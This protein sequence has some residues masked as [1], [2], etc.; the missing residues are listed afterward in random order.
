M[1]L[2]DLKAAVAAA[3]VALG[4][5]GLVVLSFGNVSG[6]D[7]AAGVLVIKPSGVPYDGLTA[8]DMVV[9]RLEDGS[10]V[11]GDLR[12]S[13]DTPTHRLLYRELPGIGGVV[14]THSREATAWAQAGRAIPCLGTTHAD[15]FRGSVPV[16]RPLRS[17]EITGEYEA[18]TGRVIVETLAS[19][20]RTALDSPAVL[21][22]GH[23]PFC[24][25]GSPADAVDTAIALEAVAA[26]ATRT[27]LIDATMGELDP[28]LLARHF[29]RKHGPAA[30]Y[31]QPDEP[32]AI[33]TGRAAPARGAG[34]GAGGQ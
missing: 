10:V 14:H 30:Y 7:R 1:A 29:D 32:S 26:M 28:E 25:G 4:R 24:W 20:G 27:L 23:G 5:S 8:D 9:V 13:T 16:S 19:A 3:N 22:R 12:P 21:V 15:H 17:A 6:V 18:E 2:A 33:E 31:G 11:E 34:D